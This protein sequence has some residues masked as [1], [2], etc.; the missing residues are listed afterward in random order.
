MKALYLLTVKHQRVFVEIVPD[1]FSAETWMS[2]HQDLF[3]AADI[4]G[5]E[6]EGVDDN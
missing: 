6:E 5:V 3:D 1:D 4:I 2:N